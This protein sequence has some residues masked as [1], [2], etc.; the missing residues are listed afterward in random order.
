M[1]AAILKISDAALQVEERAPPP[2]PLPWDA[3][4]LRELITIAKDWW[5]H[6]GRPKEAMWLCAFRPP[7]EFSPTI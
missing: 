7:K 6:T 1:I 3:E 5:V 2:L 4:D